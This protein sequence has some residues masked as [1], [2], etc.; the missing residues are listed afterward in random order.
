MKNIEVTDGMNNALNSGAEKDKCLKIANSIMDKLTD[1]CDKHKIPVN[2][3][4]VVGIEI[5]ANSIKDIGE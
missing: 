4:L 1:V 2:A 3:L 5:F